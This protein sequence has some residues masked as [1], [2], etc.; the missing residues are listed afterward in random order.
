APR[1]PRGAARARSRVP[2]PGPRRRGRVPSRANPHS[3]RHP[4]PPPSGRTTSKG[5]RM[6]ALP[7]PSPHPARAPRPRRHLEVA[8]TSTRR[9]ARPRLLPAALTMGGIAA[10]LLAQLLLSIVLADGA[11]RIAGLQGEQRTLQRQE[12]ALTEHLEVLTS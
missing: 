11:Y 7:L 1:A 6:S 12:Q 5:R 3:P 2:T 4:R 8:P 10:I 9:R